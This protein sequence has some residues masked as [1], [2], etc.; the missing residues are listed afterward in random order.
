LSQRVKEQQVLAEA[1]PDHNPILDG[2]L[3]QL[4]AKIEPDLIN[5]FVSQNEDVQIKIMIKDHD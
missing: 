1:E 3:H 4:L 5:A 2:M